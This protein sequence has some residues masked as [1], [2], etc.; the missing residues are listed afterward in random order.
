MF[1]N[2][3]I[4]K[5]ILITGHTGFKGSWLSII[6]NNLGAKVIGIAK[7]KLDKPSLYSLA[8]ISKIMKNEYFCDVSNYSKIKEIIL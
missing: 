5:K 7:Y 8:K 2:N 6:L 4:N 3:F 1:L